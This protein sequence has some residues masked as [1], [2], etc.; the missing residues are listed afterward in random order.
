MY[1]YIYI[2]ICRYM[3]IDTCVCIYTYTYMYIY[4]YIYIQSYYHLNNL[5][6]IISLEAKLIATCLAGG[7]AAERL[8]SEA[9]RQS[10]GSKA[11]GCGCR[12]YAAGGL[13]A[14]RLAP[15]GLFVETT[16]VYVETMLRV[17]WLPRDCRE[18]SPTRGHTERPRRQKSLCKSNNSHYKSNRSHFANQT[19]ITLQIKQIHNFAPLRQTSQFYSFS[20]S[21]KFKLL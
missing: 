15:L 4:I 14:E 2:S 8:A 1:V 20:K 21:D 5:H 6:F 7:L 13:A 11:T 17:A 18:T 12:D 16:G 3:Y 9:L 10:L 19:D